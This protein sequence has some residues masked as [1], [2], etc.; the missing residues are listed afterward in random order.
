MV[1]YKC[2]RCNYTTDHKS[3]MIKHWARKKICRDEN[4]IGLDPEFCLKNI[5]K[6]KNCLF[7]SE[8]QNEI[9]DLQ[10]E[11]E[12]QQKLIEEQQKQIKDLQ[13]EN[14]RLKSI[15]QSQNNQTQ[16]E[17]ECIYLLQEREFVNSGENIY[18][19]G[20][21]SNFKN[22]MSDYPKGSK[23]L[24]VKTTSNSTKDEEEL[25]KI[26]NCMFINRT[27]IGKEYFQGNLK[28]LSD[29]IDNYFV[30]KNN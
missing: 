22:R 15:I 26:F 24:H 4:G 14:K 12:K 3:T 5:K 11:T 9:I 17:E 18:K 7:K 13:Q 21:T 10:I 20:R 2:P 27:D 16:E 28:G 25:L 8:K 23:L 19:I 6:F 30:H 1:Y 29:T